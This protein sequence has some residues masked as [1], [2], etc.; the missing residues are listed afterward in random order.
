V[1]KESGVIVLGPPLM[2]VSINV[3]DAFGIGSAAA[4][5]WI[6][7]FYERRWEASCLQHSSSRRGGSGYSTMDSS[8]L[9]W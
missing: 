5:V 7:D 2:G 8:V 1:E 3:V 6:T 9:P 4:D